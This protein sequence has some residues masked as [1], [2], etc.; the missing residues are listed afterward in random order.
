MIKPITLGLLLALSLGLSTASYA[1]PLSDARAAGSIKELTSGYI[2]ATG[3]AS[4]ATIILIKDINK[5]RKAA[6]NKIAQKNNL[7]VEQ[8]GIESYKKRNP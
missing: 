4:A 2:A 8:V 1:S 7:T 6:Y 3:K 5:R